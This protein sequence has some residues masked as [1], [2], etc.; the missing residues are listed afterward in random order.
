MKEN[1][2]ESKTAVDAFKQKLEDTKK[3]IA[4][5]TTTSSESLSKIQ[6]SIGQLKGNQ[7][8]LSEESSS[9]AKKDDDDQDEK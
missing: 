9:S 5:K 1:Q 2:A 7:Q 6:E 3:E 4:L 8:A